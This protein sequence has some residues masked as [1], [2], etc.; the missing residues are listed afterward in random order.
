M[1]HSTAF[2]RP[3][4][5]VRTISNVHHT[6]LIPNINSEPNLK[7][8]LK[9]HHTRSTSSALAGAD[10]VCCKAN[11]GREIQARRLV[12]AQRLQQQQQ[13]HH[14]QQ[15]QLSLS[16]TAMCG[17]VGIL[18]GDEQSHVNQLIFDALTALQH[19]GQG[20]DRVSFELN[21]RRTMRDVVASARFCKAVTQ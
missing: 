7:F 9:V 14:H 20:K 19:R 5:A 16:H 13:Q 18:L 2:E 4:H 17:I 11:L 1:P 10:W 21:T 3:A 15:Q 6:T 12:E 8:E